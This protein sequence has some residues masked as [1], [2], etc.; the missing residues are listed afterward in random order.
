MESRDK[1]AERI[2]YDGM[3]I[4]ILRESCAEAYV[5]LAPPKAEPYVVAP[6]AMPV[7]DVVEFF[8]LQAPKLD[9][10]R[11]KMLKRFEKSGSERC[12]FQTGDI[13]YVM[14]RPFML[15]VYLLGK[16]K[17]RVR[18]GNRGRA[19][20]QHA[21]DANVS[22]LSLYVARADDYAQRRLAFLSYAETVVLRN[23]ADMAAECCRRIMPG[24]KAPRVRMRDLPERFAQVSP[25]V[26]WLSTDIVGYPVDCLV[27]AIWRAL[28]I[29][30]T[31]SPEESQRQ[32]EAILPGWE[33]AA[34]IL[35]ERAAPYSNQ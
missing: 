34:R 11:E 2:G 16:Q 3:T 9:G 5:A 10:L 23:A 14:G 7:G 32:L 8:A 18:G 22:L 6:R 25:G 35:S 33:R 20:V 1:Q 31:V 29:E 4:P 26:L 13:A 27:Y 17:Q 30:A 28:M 24:R 19:T 12:T 21:V 15:Q